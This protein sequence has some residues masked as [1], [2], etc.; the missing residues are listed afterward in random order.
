MIDHL[1]HTSGKVTTNSVEVNGTTIHPSE[2]TYGPGEVMFH[3]PSMVRSVYNAECTPATYIAF[4][5]SAKYTTV[6][7]PYIMPAFSPFTLNGVLWLVV[8]CTRHTP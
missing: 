7:I 4:Y 8:N 6:F 3:G 1:D 5:T 2:V